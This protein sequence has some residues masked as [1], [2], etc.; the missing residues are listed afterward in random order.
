MILEQDCL[1]RLLLL[2]PEDPEEQNSFKLRKV[3][4]AFAGTPWFSQLY[5]VSPKDLIALY[6]S[7]ISVVAMHAGRKTSSAYQLSWQSALYDSRLIETL[8][9]QQTFA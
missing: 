2:F 5:H 8:G 9:R 3:Q 4:E 1:N 6:F 7:G